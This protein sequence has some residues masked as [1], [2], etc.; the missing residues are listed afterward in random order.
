MND[1]SSPLADMAALG[2]LMEEY[3]PRLL[4]ML[5][6]RIDPS[7]AVRIDPEDV[8]SETFFAARRRWATFTPEAPYPWLY[9]LARDCLI[10]AWRKETRN[11]RDLHRDLPWPEGSSLQLGLSLVDPGGTPGAALRQQE[12]HER[13]QQTLRLLK[14]SD[15]EVLWMRHHDGLSAR[16]AGLVLGVDANAA[17]VRYVRALR[18]LKELW[19]KLNPEQG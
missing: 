3:R 12:L 15:R 19:I 2:K 17:Q 13:M 10:A 5:R 1:D 7:L 11:C 14:D 8:Y 16:E 4:A 9:R 6:R 18:R